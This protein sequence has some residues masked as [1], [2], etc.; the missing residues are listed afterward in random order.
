[1]LNLRKQP[2]YSAKEMCV[3][4]MYLFSIRISRHLC[5]DFGQ[6][7]YFYMHTAIEQLK[8]QS[9]IGKE[10]LNSVFRNADT[11]QNTLRI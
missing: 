1:M 2:Q 7:F 11:K 4:F 5:S 8:N 6:E 3:F 10:S 9:A